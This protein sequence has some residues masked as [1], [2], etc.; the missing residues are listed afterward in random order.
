P[1]ETSIV[2]AIAV[3]DGQP[4]T[5]GQVLIELEALGAAADV[6]KF[7]SEW[8]SARAD[9]ARLKALLTPD[10]AA[11]FAVPAD[12]PAALAERARGRTLAQAA[13]LK[14]KLAANDAEITRKQAELRT[15]DAEIARLVASEGKILDR[16]RRRQELAAQGLGSEL[17]KSRSEQELEDS[18][19]NQAVQRSRL[20]ETRAAIESLKSQRDQAKDEFERDTR[21]SL[22]EAEAK[23]ASTAQDL[24]KARDRLAVQRLTAPVDGVAQQLDVHTVGGVVQPAQKLVVVVPKD[25]VLEVEARL[26]N[27]DIGFVEPGQEVTVK[28]DPFPFTRYGTLTGR[29]ETV[30]QDAMQDEQ[31]KDWFFPLRIS[32][33]ARD[34]A[35]ENGKR[36]PLTPGMTVTAEVKTGTRHPIEYALAPLQRYGAESGRER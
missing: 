15:I 3:Q 16:T 26:P 33:A 13:G 10:P 22:A 32:L 35:V 23:A 8:N 9:A 6:G 18:R 21:A 28:L 30:S 1:I 5:A 31:K 27:K 19:G 24:A 12:L 25:A 2:K 11:A 7:E 36:V 17:E 34:I 20:A 29:I 14:S 4:V